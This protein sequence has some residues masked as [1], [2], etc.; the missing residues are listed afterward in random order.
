MVASSRLNVDYKSPI[1]LLRVATETASAGTEHYDVN[2]KS[3]DTFV[4]EANL[5]TEWTL[6]RTLTQ[7]RQGDETRRRTCGTFDA[8][9]C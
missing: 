3:E 7:D 6:L 2:S 4:F 1:T 9:Y 8:S 5:H